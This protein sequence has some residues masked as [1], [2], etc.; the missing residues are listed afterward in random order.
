M[1]DEDFEE[2]DAL[3]AARARRLPPAEGAVSPGIH[4]STRELRLISSAAM[5]LDFEVTEVTT[6]A[7]HWLPSAPNCGRHFDDPG[8]VALV[9]PKHRKDWWWARWWNLG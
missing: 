3:N 5:T 9:P 6:E 2:V 8:D 1:R 7:G 4:L